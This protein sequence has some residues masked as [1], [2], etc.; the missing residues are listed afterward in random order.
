MGQMMLTVGALVLL[1]ATILSVNSNTLQNG[2][3]LRQTEIGVYAIALATSYIQTAAELNFDEKT[4]LTPI[5]ALASDGSKLVPI[6]TIKLR[7][8][9][10]PY[11]SLGRN[12]AGEIANVD[13]TFDDF[14]DFNG[15]A[16][17][18]TAKG[19]DVFT[20]LATV[21]YVDT[22]GVTA[23]ASETPTFFK[24]MDIRTFGT[25]GRGVYEGGASQGLDT[26]KLSYIFS[27][28]R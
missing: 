19:E 25:V 16:K 11:D 23:P 27:Y 20:T 17:T 14:D 8:L 9:L 1:G 28:Y 7:K 4:V 21:Y 18:D 15:F 3:I 24:R 6:D 12:G 10:T 22:L 26:I 2:V 5:P 13:S